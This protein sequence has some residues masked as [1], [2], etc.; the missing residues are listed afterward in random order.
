VGRHVAHATR[1][2]E[3]VQGGLEHEAHDLPSRP[4]GHDAPGICPPRVNSCLSGS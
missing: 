1:A 4:P 3:G 2:L